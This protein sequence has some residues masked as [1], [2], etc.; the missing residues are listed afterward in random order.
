V[1]AGTTAINNEIKVNGLGNYTVDD[2]D[3]LITVKDL[4]LNSFKSINKFCNDITSNYSNSGS[5]GSKPIDFIVLNAGI[6]ATE[7]LERT[8]EGFEKQIGVNHFGHAYLVSLLLPMLEKTTT[9][10]RIVSV[11]SIA[12]TFTKNIDLTDLHYN[13][14]KYDRWEAYGN[15]KLANILFAKGLAKNV[16]NKLITS[17]SLHP[18]VIKSNLWN[19]NSGFLGFAFN[20]VGSIIADKT[21]PQGAATQ[22]FAC[23]APRITS[24]DMRGAYLNNNEPV[25][26]SKVAE[27]DANVDGLWS[28]TFKQID[29]VLAKQ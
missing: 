10:V 25:R 23:V 4:D 21:I 22:T 3:S 24:D 26:P 27:D 18:G 28:E 20:V 1:A 8:N 17:V 15:S 9:P 7:N 29:Q 19:R 16:K 11:A 14:K 2:A 12:H 13:N 5:S 6:M